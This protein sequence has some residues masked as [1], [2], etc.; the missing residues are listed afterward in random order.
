MTARQRRWWWAAALVG[1][2][3][4]G[5]TIAYVWVGKTVGGRQWHD[6][7]RRHRARGLAL[8]PPRRARVRRPPHGGG[9]GAAA[10]PLVS[11]AAEYGQPLWGLGTR[12][13]CV[14]DT[15]TLVAQRIV[16]GAA[17]LVQLDIAKA[18]ITPLRTA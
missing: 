2:L 18:S 8:D 3:V 12:S 11:E 4:A 1:V 17:E 10:R 13:Y 5:V 7:L 9:D 16:N 14:V 6:P 15:N